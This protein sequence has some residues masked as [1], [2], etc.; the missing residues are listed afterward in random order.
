[1]GTVL[2][3][4]CSALCGALLI[5]GLTS[6]TDPAAQARG[7]LET[8]LQALVD[9]QPD[10][11]YLYEPFATAS[12]S[13]DAAFSEGESAAG[14]SGDDAESATNGALR[15]IAAHCSFEVGAVTVDGSG[16]TA[17]AKVT[18][19]SPDMATILS[20]EAQAGTA[21]DANSLIEAAISQ[22]DGDFPTRETTLTANLYRKDDRWLLDPDAE[23]DN[24]LSGGVNQMYFSLGKSVVDALAT[25]E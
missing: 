2:R 9:S 8:T 1:M 14:A 19:T 13:E 20:E 4:A 15:A 10:Q 18:L 16:D 21:D 12:S 22:F 17:T 7:D 11:A 24:A 25:E 3:V 23:L 5:A 6:C